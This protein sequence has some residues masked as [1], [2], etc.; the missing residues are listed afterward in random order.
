MDWVSRSDAENFALNVAFLKKHVRPLNVGESLPLVFS[1]VP[2]TAGTS[3]ESYLASQ[4][5]MSESL[6]VNA[7]DLNRLPG[8]LRMKKNFQVCIK[9]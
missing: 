4:F 2:K 5:K 8:V 6:H 7:P 1:H 9:K 3:F